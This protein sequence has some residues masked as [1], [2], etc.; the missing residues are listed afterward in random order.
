M[1]IADTRR[2]SDQPAAATQPAAQPAALAAGQAAA[3][4]A[5]GDPLDG[6]VRYTSLGFDATLE[7]AAAVLLDALCRDADARTKG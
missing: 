6:G 2:R 3:V 4:Q 5:Y 1:G 7:E